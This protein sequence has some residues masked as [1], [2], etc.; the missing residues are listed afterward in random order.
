MKS[1]EALQILK[2]MRAGVGRHRAFVLTALFSSRQRLPLEFS[3]Q[4]NE[5]QKALT[6]EI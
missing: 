6:W 4:H 1:S 5:T 2:L 3:D